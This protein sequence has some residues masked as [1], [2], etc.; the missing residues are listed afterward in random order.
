MVKKLAAFVF[1][2]AASLSA[3]AASDCEYCYYGYDACIQNGNAPAVCQRQMNLCLRFC[4][5]D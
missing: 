5:I 1:A 4:I 2:V 3:S